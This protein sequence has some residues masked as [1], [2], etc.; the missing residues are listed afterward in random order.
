MTGLARITAR[1]RRELEFFDSLVAVAPRPVDFELQRTDEEEDQQPTAA[2]LEAAEREAFE[3]IC[4]KKKTPYRKREILLAEEVL[5][6]FH[7]DPV[8]HLY[9]N[10]WLRGGLMSHAVL[11]HRNRRRRVVRLEESW[12]PSW[13]VPLKLLRDSVAVYDWLCERLRVPVSVYS[14]EV[15]DALATSICDGRKHREHRWV[16][17][18]HAHGQL[19]LVR[20]TFIPARETAREGRVP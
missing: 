16:D 13:L 8:S 19:V 12:A 9:R 3:A 17:R 4:A 14:D 10:L 6:A 1:D 11:C 18:F 20:Y 15:C 5:P 2:E 7:D